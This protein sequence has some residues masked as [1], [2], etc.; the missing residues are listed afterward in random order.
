MVPIVRIDTPRCSRRMAFRSIGL[1]QRKKDARGF[2]LMMSDVLAALANLGDAF[3]KN[4]HSK[5]IGK[6]RTVT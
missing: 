2:M 1:E 5:C 6:S 3:A 4:D